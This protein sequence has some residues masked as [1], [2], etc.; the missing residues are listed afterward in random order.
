MN[1]DHE[2]LGKA[3]KIAAEAHAGQVDKAG[4]PYILHPLRVCSKC[5][6]DEERIVALLHDTLEDT[7]VT[8]GH[9]LSE[10]FPRHIVEAILSVSRNKDESYED[11]I[12]RARSNPL[13]RQ[14]K[15]HDLEDNMDLTRLNQVTEK[16]VIRLNRYL[17]AYSYLRANALNPVCQKE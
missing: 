10:G 13:G 14:V 1:T 4:R 12:R 3:L 6:T 8:A 11:F 2:L 5:A 7:E 15:L 17:N 9:L 16:D